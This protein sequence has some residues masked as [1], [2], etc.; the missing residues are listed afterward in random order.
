MLQQPISPIRSRNRGEQ[1]F[2]SFGEDPLL[3]AR[4]GGIHATRQ[5][6]QNFSRSWAIAERTANALR[7]SHESLDING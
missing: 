4:C 3:R 5:A 7:G 2:P 1:R 6:L